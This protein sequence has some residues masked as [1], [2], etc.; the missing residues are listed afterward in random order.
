MAKYNKVSETVRRQ[1]SEREV[2]GV[3]VAYV[4]WSVF[5]RF[6][7]LA[8]IRKAAAE[9]FPGV[10]EDKLIVRNEGEIVFDIL[11]QPIKK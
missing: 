7:T 3:R 2:V 9:A 10:P 6:P 4:K 8:E 5:K 11:L 1:H